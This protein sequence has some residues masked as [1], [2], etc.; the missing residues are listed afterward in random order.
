[1]EHRQLTVV[2]ALI[3]KNGK[4]LLVRRYDPDSPH[5][6]HRWQMPGGKINPGETPLEALHR[7]VFEETSLF[8]YSPS[9]LGIHT[10]HWDT[11]T[12]VQQTFLIAYH[13]IANQSEV[14]LF[15][16]ENDDYSWE[17]M[18][19]LLQRRDLLDGT[20]ELLEALYPSRRG[21]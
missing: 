11:P 8:V 2:V 14:S 5:W 10:H 1:V 18:P 20:R 21:P 9:L 17:E 15:T 19:K 4:Y 7:E 16:P 3:E 6:H 12:G 13:C